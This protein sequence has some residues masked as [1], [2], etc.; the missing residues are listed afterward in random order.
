M[1][2]IMMTVCAA[3]ARISTKALEKKLWG[4]QQS[5]CKM[6][7]LA[8]CAEDNIVSAYFEV[9]KSQLNSSLKLQMQS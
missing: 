8:I 3:Q 4:Q 1:N 7:I 6:T 5:V 9:M 2:D